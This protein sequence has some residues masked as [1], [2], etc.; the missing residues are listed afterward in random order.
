MS[1]VDGVLARLSRLGGRRLPS[2]RMIGLGLALLYLSSGLYSVSTDQQAVVLRWGR[3]QESRVP[4]GVHWAWPAPI[5]EVRRLKVRE[6]KRLALGF[7]PAQPTAAAQFLTGDRNILNVRL[8]VQYAINDP[9]A[10]LFR[11][12]DVNALIGTAALGALVHVIAERH[13]DD[14]LTT[15][16]IAVQERVQALAQSTLE[17]YACGVSLIAVALETVQPPDEVVDAFRLVASAREDSSRIVREAESYANGVVPI[18]RGNAMKAAEEA[19]TYATQRVDEAAGSAAKFIA[20]SEEYTRAPQQT[21]TRLYLETLEQVLPAMNK[22]LVGVD[23]KTV[24]LQFFRG[25]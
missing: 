7:D 16:K 5:G 13:V 9:V 21:A 12:H 23:G 25:K 11:A 10:Y 8:V 6:T 1:A 2:R 4:A 22:T 19:Q 3:I 18:A 24:D 14:L 15:E 20:M 17:R